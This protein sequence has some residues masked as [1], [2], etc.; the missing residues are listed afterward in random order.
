[1]EQAL[2]ASAAGPGSGSAAD[3]RALLRSESAEQWLKAVF[4]L[5]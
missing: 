3:R 4:R 1:M 5:A 2:T